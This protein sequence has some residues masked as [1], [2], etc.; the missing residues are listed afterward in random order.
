MQESRL[1]VNGVKDTIVEGIEERDEETWI[2]DHKELGVDS[3]PIKALRMGSNKDVFE[4]FD[5]NNDDARRVRKGIHVLLDRHFPLP[6]AADEAAGRGDEMREVREVREAYW[7][8]LNAYLDAKRG[9][10]PNQEFLPVQSG[11]PFGGESIVQSA[12]RVGTCAEEFFTAHVMLKGGEK[13]RPYLHGVLHSEAQI[14]ARGPPILYESRSLEAEQ[15]AGN[16]DERNLVSCRPLGSASG[17]SRVEITTCPPLEMLRCAL[18]RRV[19]ARAAPQ[20][21]S[22]RKRAR[23]GR[24]AHPRKMARSSPAA[25]VP[26]CAKR[27][28]NFAI[29]Q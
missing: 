2:A 28:T 27:P 4:N 16:A 5:Y 14:R 12:R 8:K 10:R 6:T 1:T 17:V 29:A 21:T 25:Q 3:G 23:E 19:A 13:I 18:R 11:V 20:Q 24:V 15:A 9:I 22:W 26:G 7:A